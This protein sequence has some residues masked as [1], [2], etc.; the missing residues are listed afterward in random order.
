MKSMMYTMVLIIP[1]WWFFGSNYADVAINLPIPIPFWAAFDWFNPLSWFSF[2]L[3]ES[4]SWIGWYIL[5]SL[6][7]SIAFGLG[8]KIYDKVRGE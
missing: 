5:I 1:L 3:F 2:K 7:T 8:I 6:L 4:T